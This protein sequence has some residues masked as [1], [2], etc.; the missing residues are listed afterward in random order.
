MGSLGSCCSW[1]KRQEGQVQ[2]SPLEVG[3]VRSLK[4][5]S[6]SLAFAAGSWLMLRSLYARG[7][8]SVMVTT[9]R[10]GLLSEFDNAD[11]AEFYQLAN[12]LKLHGYWL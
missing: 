11:N 7:M 9:L 4:L 1:L 2:L 12:W 6:Y 3:G 8:C 5:S 10:D